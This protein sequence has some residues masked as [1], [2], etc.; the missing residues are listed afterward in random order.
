LKLCLQ[1]AN[2]VFY[3][4]NNNNNNNNNNWE[5]HLVELVEFASVLQKN[6]QLRAEAQIQIFGP[7]QCYNFFLPVVK[8]S[9]D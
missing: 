9:L 7:L 6:D 4:Y 1:Q 5:E 3:Y 2:S 8:A